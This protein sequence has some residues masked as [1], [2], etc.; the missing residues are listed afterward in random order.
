MIFFATTK[1]NDHAMAWYLLREGA[2]F[3]RTIVPITYDDLLGAPALPRATYCFSDLELLPDVQREPAIALW[4]RLDAQECRLLNHPEHML[5]R[6]DLLRTLRDDGPNRF[7]VHR[8][9]DDLSAVRYPVFLRN[10]LDHEGRTS[11]L[12]PDA[13]A[14]Q[15]A[16]PEQHTVETDAYRTLVVE[17]VDTSDAA[18]VFRKYAA[19]IVGDTVLARHLMCS[20]DWQV[21]E[22]DLLDAEHLREELEYVESNP[23]E[24]QLRELFAR[25]HVDYG[26]IDYSFLDGV[27]QVWEINTNPTLVMPT[28]NQRRPRAPVRDL[29]A[30]RLAPCWTALDR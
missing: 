4:D 6:Y 14:L 10:E 19:F 26:R 21:K 27:M 13:A 8:T 17:F 2:P 30:A 9:T 18:G 15:V 28:Y 16:L 12:L 7:T 22:A 3:R 5:A 11:G 20:T 29:F 24:E 1:A 25:A 23:H